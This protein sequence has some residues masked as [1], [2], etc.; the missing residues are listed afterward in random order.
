MCHFALTCTCTVQL[1]YEIL[2]QERKQFWCV[3]GNQSPR[4]KPTLYDIGESPTLS[5]WSSFDWKLNLIPQRWQALMFA[6]HLW[7]MGNILAGVSLRRRILNIQILWCM[8]LWVWLGIEPRTSEMTGTDVSSH[9]ATT[10]SALFQGLT[11]VLALCW[12][13]MHLSIFWR[14]FFRKTRQQNHL[15]EV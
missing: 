11:L 2:S 6:L 13:F 15:N 3:K 8:H 12:F 4:R 1:S 10:L 9:C 5:L 14:Q 7:K